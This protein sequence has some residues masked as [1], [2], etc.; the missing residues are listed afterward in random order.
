MGLFWIAFSLA[1]LFLEMITQALVSIWFVMGGTGAYIAMKVGASV[2]VQLVVCGAISVVGI[3]FWYFVIK[4]KLHLTQ[5]N[6]DRNIG[7]IGVVLQEI[8]GAEGEGTVKLGKEKW[9]AA[10]ERQDVIIPS[11]AKVEVI[12]IEGCHLIVRKIENNEKK[13]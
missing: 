8:N 6:E 7:K 12:G 2:A 5:T 9:T 1:F 4:D 3:I 13:E 10:G 11:N